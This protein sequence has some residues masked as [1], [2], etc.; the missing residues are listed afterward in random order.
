VIEAVTLSAQANARDRMPRLLCC[1]ILALAGC[2]AARPTVPTAPA[3]REGYFTGAEG[4][5]LHYRA[6]GTGTD[7]VA[8]VHGQQGNTLEYL[9]PD[10]VPLAQ[11][12]VVLAY[13]QRGGGRSDAVSEPERLGI[14]SPLAPS[15]VVCCGAP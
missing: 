3:T 14:G 1:L 11:G 5:R 4:V 6:M 15:R 12:R 9:A 2:S 8:L 13:T 10:L 7:T